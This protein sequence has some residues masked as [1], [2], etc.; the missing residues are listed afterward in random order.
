MEL[1]IRSGYFMKV[2]IVLS[3]CTQSKRAYG[4]R[5][6][7]TGKNQWDCDWAFPVDEARAKREG[8]DRVQIKGTFSISPKY[9]GCPSCGNKSF[10][11]CG[12]CSKLTCW[13]SNKKQITCAWCGT[14]GYI[15]SEIGDMEGGGF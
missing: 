11:K 8:Y 15:E 1:K 12:K 2:F 4:I 13:D 9:P 14:Q 5:V 7:D 10:F 3:K 6:E